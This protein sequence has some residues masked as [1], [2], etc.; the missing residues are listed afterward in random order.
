M[1]LKAA[2]DEFILYIEIEKN[3]STHT[4]TSYE[5][6][7]QHF[8]E[9]LTNHQCSTDLNEITKTLVR[10]FIRYELS[11]RHQQARSVN[12]KISSL[13]SFTKFCLEEKYLQHDF[14]TG[15]ETPKTDA[16]LP[17]YMTV[18]DLQQLFHSLEQDRSRLAQR[19]E[20]MFKLLV[21]TGM[22]RS[23]LV[24]LTWEQLDFTNETVKIY[25]KG[26]KERLLPLHP[27]VMHS[28]GL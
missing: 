18:K 14:M 17:V 23:E 20:L 12:R 27:Q 7:L 11:T 16:K 24:S 13:K 6:D 21:T 1:Q 10:R 3:Y 19:N 2:I 8:L 5:Y 9:F 25:G 4:V 15:I 22:R 26:K 28:N